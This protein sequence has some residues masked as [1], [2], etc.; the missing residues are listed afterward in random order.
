[1]C[2]VSEEDLFQ[3]DRSIRISLGEEG[4]LNEHRFELILCAECLLVLE[5]VCRILEEGLPCP[6]QLLCFYVAVRGVKL[7]V[8]LILFHMMKGGRRDHLFENQMV[9]KELIV[10][11]LD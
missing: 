5:L 9:G 2:L 1:M 8:R 7:G 4:T 10:R 6:P 3:R 11:V